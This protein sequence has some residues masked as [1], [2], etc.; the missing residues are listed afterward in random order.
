MEP[1]QQ[2]KTPDSIIR[3]LDEIKNETAR[4]ARD[5][6]RAETEYLDAKREFEREFALSYR[7]ADGPVED[8]KQQAAL[9]A[10]SFAQARD[11]AQAV[12]NYRKQRSRD[13]DQGQSA[14]QTQARLVEITYRLAGV[15]Q[16]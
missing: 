13:L 7:R 5:I 4:R 11:D 9:D 3:E 6:Q 12:L 15:N 2:I 1:P 14:L 16:T 8:R 10:D